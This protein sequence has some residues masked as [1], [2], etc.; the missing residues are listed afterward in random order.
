MKNKLQVVQNKIVR[1]ILQLHPRKSVTYIEFEKL[2]FLNISNR[3]KQL[4]LNHVFNIFNNICPNYLHT[5]FVRKETSLNTRSSSKN[6]Y[7]PG[8]KGCESTTFFYN[9]I[10]DWNSLPEII[11]SC[12]KKYN[13]KA[14]VKK[15]MMDKFKSIFDSEFV[16]Y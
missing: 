11:K 8:I 2:G 5:N 13:F 14:Q 6:F 12:S 7:I 4:R 1:F 10:R 16:Y 9:G 15:F 3:V